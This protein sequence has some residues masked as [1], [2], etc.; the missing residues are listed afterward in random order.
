MADN[1]DE[2]IMQF[3]DLTGTSPGKVTLASSWN[4]RDTDHLQAQQYL[5]TNRWDLN[6]AVTEYFASLDEGTAGGPMDEDEPEPEPYTG[7]RTLDGRPAPESIP[8]VG[9]SSKA[10]PK[11]KGGFAT[12]G[13]LGQAGGAG[14]HAGHGH[15]HDDDDDSDD[16]DFEPGEEPRDL[17]AGG[18]KSGL[19]VQDPSNRDRNDPRKVV[20]DILKKARA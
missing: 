8:S 7:P 10:P 11:K 15:S 9:S 4:L 20:N 5:G 1:Q 3:V 16:D 17:F 2:L 14:G 13:S 6:S 18:E 12:L 19:A